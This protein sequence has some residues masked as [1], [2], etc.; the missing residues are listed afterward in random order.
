MFRLR[1]LCAA[2]LLVCANSEFASLYPPPSSLILNRAKGLGI[3]LGLFL[4]RIQ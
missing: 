4:V 1:P 3:K 2:Y